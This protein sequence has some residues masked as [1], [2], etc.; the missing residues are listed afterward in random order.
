[1]QNDAQKS[2]IRFNYKYADFVWILDDESYFTLTNCVINR[3]DNFY[4]SK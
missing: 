1:M 2:K 4:S 3:S